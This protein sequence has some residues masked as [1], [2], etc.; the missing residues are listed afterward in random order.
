M[1]KLILVCV[2]LLLSGCTSN[3][4]FTEIKSSN[5]N[6]NVRSFLEAI[7]DENGTY[8]YFNGEKEI[9]VFLNGSNV[10]QG[11]K[12]AYFSNFDVVDDGDTLSTIK[13]KPLPTAQKFHFIW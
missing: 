3:L 12:A 2:I 11:D 1:K 13:S 8:L 6:K 7:D 9:F 4:T 5:V 10:Q